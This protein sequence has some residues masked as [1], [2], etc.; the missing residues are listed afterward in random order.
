MATRGGVNASDATQQLRDLLKLDR[1]PEQRDPL[2]A[3]D[4]AVVSYNGQLNGMAATAMSEVPGAESACSMSAGAV[5]AAAVLPGP[6]PHLVDSQQITLT[7]DD[8]AGAVPV[9]AREVVVISSDASSL[10]SPSSGSNQVKIQPVTRYDWEHRYYPG[11]MIAV[12]S[13]YLAYIIPKPQAMVRVL[14]AP[15]A[16]RTLLKGFTGAVTDLA[17]AHLGS[18][19]LACVDEAGNLFVWQFSQDSCGKIA[20]KQL[21]QAMRPVGTPLSELRRIQW[22]PFIY[23]NS[24]RE[25]ESD[26][27]EDVG[28]ML[29]LFH[30]D[31]A[32]AW[33]QD[34]IVPTSGP[35]KPVAVTDIKNRITTVR[36]HEGAVNTGALSPD[37]AILATAG[38]DGLVKFWQMYAESQDTPSCLHKWEPHNGMPVSCLLFCDNY[39]RKEGG[40]QYWRFVLTGT[41]QN[42]ELKVWCTVTWTCLQTLRFSPDSAIKL[43]LDITAQYLV[44]SDVQR[45]VLYVLELIQNKDG[46]A[47]FSSLAEYLLTHPMLSFGIREVTPHRAGRQSEHQEDGEVDAADGV[48]DEAEVTGGVLIKINCVHTRALEN[49][50]ILFCPPSTSGAA[51]PALSV[52]SSASHEDMVLRDRLSD[53]SSDLP[54]EENSSQSSD[55]QRTFDDNRR[56]DILGRVDLGGGAALLSPGLGGGAG[57]LARPED[58]MSPLTPAGALPD[59]AKLQLKTPDDFM[60][61]LVPKQLGLGSPTG[62][63]SS[64]TAVTMIGSNVLSQS[65][66]M[67]PVSS[68]T[69]TP[70]SSLHSSLSM[71]PG[72][73][74]SGA[75]PLAMADLT[76]ASPPR[77]LRSPDV[78]SSASSNSTLPQVIPEVASEA[79]QRGLRDSA[80]QGARLGSPPEQSGLLGQAGSRSR[81]PDAPSR[82][83][84]GSM[85]A[86][87]LDAG[88][89]LVSPLGQSSLGTVAGQRQMPDNVL[90]GNYSL[91]RH[92]PSEAGA[93]LAPLARQAAPGQV[94][95][96]QRAAEKEDPP[97]QLYGQQQQQQQEQQQDAAS[98]SPAWPA[99][100]DLTRETR[101]GVK[102]SS[103]EDLAMRR[104]RASPSRER[105]HLTAEQQESQDASSEH[106]D[107]DEEVAF[108]SSP[109]G[110]VA[111]AGA[112]GIAGPHRGPPSQPGFRDQ[113]GRVSP[114]LSPKSRRR[115]TREES[116]RASHPSASDQAREDG[117]AA[118]LACFTT[119]QTKLA[120]IWSRQEEMIHGM[121]AREEAL[122]NALL[123]HMEASLAKSREQDQTWFTA[124]LQQHED[125]ER[126]LQQQLQHNLTQAMS[127][128]VAARLDKGMRD[129]VKK[130]FPQAIAKAVEP[131]AAQLT[132]TM[133]A[134]LTAAEVSTRDGIAKMVKAKAISDAIGKAAAECLQ[135]PMQ[136]A[137]REA[138]QGS[139]APVFDRACQALM[140]QINEVFHRGTHEYVQQ[141]ESHLAARRQADQGALEGMG[142][143]L[144]Q[145]LMA[146][147]ASIQQLAPALSASVHTDIQAQMRD[148]SCSLQEGLT[149]TVRRVVREEMALALKEQHA[150]VTNSIMQAVRSAASTPVPSAHHPP[151][152]FRVQQE[153]IMQLLQQGQINQ[154][155][156]QA[157]TAADLELVLFVCETVDPAQVF[158]PGSCPLTQPVLLSL[159][160]Q[161]S[162]DLAVHTKTTLRF[163][164]EAVMSLDP[165]HSITREHS[166]TVLV[167]VQQ[168]MHAFLAADQ[169]GQFSKQARILLMAVGS[170]LNRHS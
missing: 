93:H 23:G 52:S 132:S 114:R 91:G 27:E 73:P 163:L 87:P 111:G 133:A 122:N 48:E 83:S 67:S 144:Q 10:S 129:E 121:E 123:S 7:G 102:V 88:P 34:V 61:S 70:G 25:S 145:T 50:Q 94:V 14:H 126:A 103:D 54:I 141:L 157:L 77:E 13:T 134:K 68:M 169:R 142:T 71:P 148:V 29:A 168:K 86:P 58:F 16:E 35:F 66:L 60:S 160:Q 92:S 44:L 84:F 11:N 22:C 152:D 159:V 108:L 120:A 125:R 17:F 104:Q 72:G 12:S 165:Q 45:K 167:P 59:D 97:R 101:S 166:A 3:A 24:D 74:H 51:P 80:E 113:K 63:G 164:E 154:A 170:L 65:P 112:A 56:D 116:E 95:G 136:V 37:G 137:F 41:N 110:V 28:K 49:V 5:D 1:Q 147:Q 38:Q 46:H 109:A 156:Q 106:S 138:F 15:T 79:V 149:G 90:R 20:T 89:R 2:S 127:G 57:E 69:L 146:M 78:I 135:G 128:V 8:K 139:A 33:D 115:A 162:M 81:S 32:E 96:P 62:S 151:I 130:I 42:Q 30:P 18:S 143:Q 119:L 150:T 158:I 98:T 82:G 21:L 9:N 107:Q 43:S 53:I 31:R 55:F 4:P 124:K 85:D 76:N 105:Q 36:G 131:L 6:A 40:E 155:F 19:R 26:G 39:K 140:Q 64:L 47:Y 153:H 161:L 75:S 100:P 99:A 117:Q 118:M